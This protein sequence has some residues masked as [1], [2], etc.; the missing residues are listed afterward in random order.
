[1]S[2]LLNDLDNHSQETWTA[3]HHAAH[4]GRTKAVLTLLEARVYNDKVRISSQTQP[5]LK[6]HWRRALSSLVKDRNA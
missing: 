6:P 2:A 4:D 1:M 5:M 3:L